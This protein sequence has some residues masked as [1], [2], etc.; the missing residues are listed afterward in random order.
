MIGQSV[1]RRAGDRADFAAL[2]EIDFVEA[3]EIRGEVNAGAADQSSVNDGTLRLGFFF[4]SLAK[5]IGLEL[6]MIR[7][8]VL[9]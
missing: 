4:G 3:P 9:R 8:E 7:Q 6:R 2:D 1:K 5:C